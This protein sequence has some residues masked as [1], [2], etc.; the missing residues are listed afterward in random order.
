[1]QHTILA[2]RDFIKKNG[3]KD[4]YPEFTAIEEDFKKDLMRSCSYCGYPQWS[5]HQYE[6]T[7][8]CNK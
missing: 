4:P 1:M 5:P 3:L 6:V 8:K 2:L 7:C